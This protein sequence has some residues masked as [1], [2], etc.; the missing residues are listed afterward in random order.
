MVLGEPE[1]LQICYPEPQNGKE[2]N[3]SYNSGLLTVGTSLPNRGIDKTSEYTGPR[4][5]ETE[6]SPIL[7]LGLPGKSARPPG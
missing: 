4:G 3:Q 1:K 6:G 7:A 2:K 5:R